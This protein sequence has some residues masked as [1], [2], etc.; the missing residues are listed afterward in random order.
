MTRKFIVTTVILLFGVLVISACSGVIPQ[1]G[2]LTQDDLIA[3]QNVVIKQAAEATATQMA[4]ATL[5]SQLQTQA[6]GG[7]GEPLVITATPEPQQATATPEPTATLEPTATHTNTPVPTATIMLPTWTPSATPVPCNAAQ[8]VS[9]VN[10]PDGTE[11][12]PGSGFYK[13]WRLK[14]VG[15]CTWTTAYAITFVDGTSM[16]ESSVVYLNGNVA[17]GQVVDVTAYMTAP[18]MEGSYRANWKL[19]DAYGVL[20]GVGTRNTSFFVDIK[21]KSQ[22]ISSR[23]PLDFAATFCNAEWVTGAGRLPCPTADNDS[24][25]YVFRTTQPVLENGYVDDEASLVM[26]PH[27]ITDGV[28]RGRY[29]SFRVEKGHHFRALISCGRDQKSCDVKFQLD[30]QLGDGSIQTLATWHERYDEQ[31]SQVDVDLSSLEGKDVMFILS[32]FANG[33]SSQDRVVWVSPRI[34]K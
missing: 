20:F 16:H 31:Y 32:V 34:E 33:S 4:M 14:N 6:A 28:I 15:S 25:G 9:D 19:R 22:Q 2:G 30:Y 18:S 26:H 8:F 1:T 23:F 7:S 24:R 13:T 12:A 29:P 3:T 10:V 27:M 11:F 5:I 21:V 17:P